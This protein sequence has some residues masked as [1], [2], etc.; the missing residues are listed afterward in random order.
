MSEPPDD[1]R[2]ESL[3]PLIAQRLTSAGSCD[4]CCQ[5]RAHNQPDAP[6]SFWSVGCGTHTRAR[7][8]RI[9]RRV[10]LPP[11]RYSRRRQNRCLT[12][13]S[14]RPSG[15][16]RA[17]SAATR[18]RR[19]SISARAR[20]RRVKV[21]KGLAR[22]DV[23]ALTCRA[24][25]VIVRRPLVPRVT[26]LSA[27]PSA[28]FVIHRSRKATLPT[29]LVI[30]FYRACW[31]SSISSASEA[32]SDTSTPRAEAIRRTVPQACARPRCD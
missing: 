19:V 14:G 26:A 12:P 5:G 23:F 7:T 18:P 32:S 8:V 11:L 13:R 1:A 29:G 22:P 4:P 25:T 3:G 6:A 9:D 21:P 15:A 30:D 10:C 20:P 31:V 17:L 16:S 24:R 28:C 27:F 2:P